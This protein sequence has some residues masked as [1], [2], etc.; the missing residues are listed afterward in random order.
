MKTD[1]EILAE[2]AR[3]G[4]MYLDCVKE[5][6]TKARESEREK[7]RKL[8]KEN[9]ELLETL[10]SVLCQACESRGSTDTEPPEYDSMALSAYADGLRLLSKHKLFRIHSETGRRVIGYMRYL[11][12]ERMSDKIILDAC[13]GAR[14][15]WFDKKHPKALYMDIRSM[16]AGFIK[17]RPN[18]SVSPDIIADFRK[19]PFGSQTF[20]LVV[21]DPPHFRNLSPDGWVAKKYGSLN[22][23]T[24][25]A[26]LQAGFNEIWRVLQNEG[27]LVFKWSC[28]K[29]KRK[30][31]GIGI[32]EILKL[33]PVAPIFGSRPNAK[34]T[35][36]W[37]IFFKSVSE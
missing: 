6:I 17:A 15:I 4:K 13:C 3:C 35:T 33:F 27:V 28:G 26:D 25:K 22:K 31:R 10:Q 1:D 5:A 24:W 30:D 11:K 14:S 8:E 19:M 32:T 34:T 16:P 2:S 36:Y 23:D 18:F 21:W 37:L 29:E 9:K 20:K 7:T 12:V